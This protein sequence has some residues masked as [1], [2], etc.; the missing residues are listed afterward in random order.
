MNPIM[1]MA[2]KGR[3]KKS[4]QYSLNASNVAYKEENS[5]LDFG[6]DLVLVG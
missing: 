2:K 5:D 1:L 4:Q 3:K 6:H